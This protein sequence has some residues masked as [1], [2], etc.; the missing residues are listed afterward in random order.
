MTLECALVNISTLVCGVIETERTADP[1]RVITFGAPEANTT[2]EAD[3]ARLEQVLIN[4]IENARKYSPADQPIDVRVD[5]CGASV[6]I[7]V[8]DRGIGVPPEDYER[9]FER[10]HRSANVD[11]GVSGLGL[12]LH[13]AREIVRAHNGTLTVASAQGEGSTFTVELPLRQ[14]KSLALGS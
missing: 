14:D 7:S 9:I 3:A 10:F 12:G 8:R 5:M 6:T 1:E 13:I 11:K 4:L 2:I